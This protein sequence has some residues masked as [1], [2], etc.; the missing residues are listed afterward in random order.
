MTRLW[1]IIDQSVFSR[2]AKV[3]F[4]RHVSRPLTP[5]E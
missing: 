3:L 5:Y 2:L 4:P 1:R